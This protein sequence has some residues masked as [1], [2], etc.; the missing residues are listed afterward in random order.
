MSADK[1]VVL[2][3]AVVHH[4]VTPNPES[5]KMT[6]PQTRP[7]QTTNISIPWNLQKGRFGEWGRLRADGRLFFSPVVEHAQQHPIRWRESERMNGRACDEET[8]KG[9]RERGREHGGG[10]EGEMTEIRW[11]EPTSKQSAVFEGKERREQGGKEM[12]KRRCITGVRVEEEADGDRDLDEHMPAQISPP[13]AESLSGVQAEHHFPPL[14]RLVYRDGT[15]MLADML[16]SFGERRSLKQ[17][18]ACGELI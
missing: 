14:F 7:E 12:E 10:G 4:P 6:Q 13:G 2:V 16:S 18:V 8:E 3:V 5:N 15:A 9:K 11:G 17:P 1:C